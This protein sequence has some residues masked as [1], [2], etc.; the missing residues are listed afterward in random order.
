[1]SER[2]E[3]CLTCYFFE[4]NCIPIDGESQHDAG[5]RAAEHGSCAGFCRRYP[6][7]TNEDGSRCAPAVDLSDWC[8]E[9]RLSSEA[10]EEQHRRDA[11]MR[12]WQHL[13]EQDEEANTSSG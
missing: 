13:A 1:M 11:T 12:K 8:G 9:W 6:P 3:S 7:Y 10:E 5:V 4:P 2:R